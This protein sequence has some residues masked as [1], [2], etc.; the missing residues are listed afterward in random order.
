[1]KKSRIK[2]LKAKNGE[3]TARLKTYNE[4]Q[5]FIHSRYNPSREADRLISA[6]NIDKKDNII[7]F[8]FGLGYH[9]EK[10]L[11]LINKKQQ[12]YLI[13]LNK[14]LFDI[15]VEVRKLKKLFF[16]KRLNVIMINNKKNV[17]LKLLDLLNNSKGKSVL[18]KHDPSI[19]IIPERLL[20]M[21]DILEDINLVNNNQKRY[22][23]EIEFNI[24]KNIESIN[25]YISINDFE[26]VFYKK[27]FFIVSA[28]PSLEKNIDD[29]KQIESKGIIISVDTALPKLINYDIIPDFTVSIDSVI[30]T[31]NMFYDVINE[32]RIPLIFTLGTSR[33]VVSKFNGPKIIGLSKNELLMDK[34]DNKMNIGRIETGA[35]VASAALDFANKCGGD[36]LVLVGQDFALT[37]Q[38]EVH[39]KNTIKNEK[40]LKE[41]LLR[42][43][44]GVNQQEVYTSKG[45]YLLLRRFE[46]Y[47]SDNNSK[48]F[49]DATEGGAKI[50]GAKIMNLSTSINKFCHKCLNKNEIIDDIIYNNERNDFSVNNLKKIIKKELD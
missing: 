15:S 21:K 3:Y 36:P 11:N 31:D 6:Y 12:I 33:E 39:A 35:S 44:E 25:K 23:S 42:K 40:K 26:N 30:N 7:V 47:V 45:Y 16:D 4:K 41:S 9:V 1:M 46:K 2:L 8:G 50:K 19:K 28:G 20:F 34:L 18:I 49:I 5:I 14:D 32:I 17:K 27:P 29:L 22:G 43:V 24:I 13:V 48:L 37:N 10:L 38:G